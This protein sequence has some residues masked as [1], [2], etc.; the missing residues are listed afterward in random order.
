MYIPN[1]YLYHVFV[2]TVLLA[3]TNIEFVRRLNKRKDIFNSTVNPKNLK[4]G[5]EIVS[6]AQNVTQEQIF[7]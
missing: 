3:A 6:Y 2:W 5:Y 4:A 1:T 7:L